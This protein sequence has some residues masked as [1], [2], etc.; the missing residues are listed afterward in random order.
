MYYYKPVL[1]DTSLFGR[2]VIAHF[3]FFSQGNTCGSSTVSSQAG[4]PFARRKVCLKCRGSRED[5]TTRKATASAKTKC[6]RNFK[7]AQSMS[8]NLLFYG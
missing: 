4:V 8:E 5:I 2:P 7:K 3:F 1:N 6:Q